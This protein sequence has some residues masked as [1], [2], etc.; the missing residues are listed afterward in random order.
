MQLI[1]FGKHILFV[2][3]PFATRGIRQV[4]TTTGHQ[5]QHHTAPRLPPREP[6]RHKV[7]RR[8]PEAEVIFRGQD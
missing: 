3:R 2:A 1:L 8:R 5:T 4:K 7:R 6:G